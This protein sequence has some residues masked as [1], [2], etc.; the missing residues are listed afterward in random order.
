M[1]FRR[2]V[3]I[4]AAPPVAVIRTTGMPAKRVGGWVGGLRE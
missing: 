2:A 4:V 1:L 3:S